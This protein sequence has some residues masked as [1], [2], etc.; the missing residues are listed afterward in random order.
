MGVCRSFEPVFDDLEIDD[1]LLGAVRLSRGVLVGDGHV[2]GR[3]ESVDTV[4]LDVAVPEGAHFLARSNQG[5]GFAKHF[6]VRDRE[7]VVG[8][9]CPLGGGSKCTRTFIAGR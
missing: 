8:L 3:G 7:L 4:A 2:M 6:D 9:A 1:G 5:N